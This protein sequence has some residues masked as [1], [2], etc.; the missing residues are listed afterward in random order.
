MASDTTA[1]HTKAPVENCFCIKEVQDSLLTNSNAS[2]LSKGD[3]LSLSLVV[4]LA[5][6][7]PAS[8]TVAVIDLLAIVEDTDLDAQLFTFQ[9]KSIACFRK[10]SDRTLQKHK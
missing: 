3:L 4:F 8:G 6:L 9:V 10:I 5:D 2:P 7:E 1:C